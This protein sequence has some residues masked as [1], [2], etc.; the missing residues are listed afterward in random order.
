MY[1]IYINIYKY[2]YIY[3]Y[4]PIVHLIHVTTEMI[5]SSHE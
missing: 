2:I 1:N 3:I 5:K 4:F